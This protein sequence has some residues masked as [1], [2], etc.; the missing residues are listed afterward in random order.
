MV[1]TINHWIG[2][3]DAIRRFKIA[4]EASWNDG[5]KLPHM[6][7]IGCPGTGKT[8]LANLAA[9][10]MG[11]QL[12]E[13][14]AQVVNSMGALNGLLVR[15]NDKDIVFLDEI[16]ELLPSVQTLLYRAMEGQR[17]SLRTRDERTLTMPLKN[18]T[19]IGATTDEYRLLSPLRQ[20][21]PVSIPFT[22]YDEE[23][24]AR[25]TL[26]RAQLAEIDV[27]PEIAPEIARRSKGTPRLAIRLLESCHRYARSVGDN[28]LTMDHF[29]ATVALDN[30]DTLGLGLDEQRFIKFL[31][32]RRGEPVRLFTLEA[33]IGVH[34]RTISDVIEPFLIREGLIERTPQGR[35]ITERGIRHVEGSLEAEPVSEG[36]S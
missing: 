5:T 35:V 33:A 28:R 10:E 12:H 26:Q 16:H 2:Q 29:E 3:D 30:L 13:R 11:V 17:I 8:L 23:S 4:L 1:P 27:E 14:I 36:A 6:L 22:T 21:F 9:K 31:T 24:L 19:V 18:F 20:R 34:R 15:A 32:K 25:I 7:F